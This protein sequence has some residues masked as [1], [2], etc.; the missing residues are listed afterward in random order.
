MNKSEQI[1]SLCI[2]VE[3]QSNVINKMTAEIGNYDVQIAEYRQI[4]QELSNKLK[5]YE[6]KYGKV[7]KRS[8]D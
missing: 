4:I 1:K 8:E 2:T 7:F 5:M 6:S 3:D